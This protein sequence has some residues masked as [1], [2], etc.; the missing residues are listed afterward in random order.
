MRIS[1][2]GESG[3]LEFREYD[4]EWGTVCDHGFNREAADVACKQM[5]YRRCDNVLMHQQ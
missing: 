3:R 5:G 2:G 1:G 4:G